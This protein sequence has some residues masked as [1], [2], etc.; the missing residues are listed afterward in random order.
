MG[1]NYVMA[2]F[3]FDYLTIRAALSFLI[4]FVTRMFETKAKT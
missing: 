4:C 1:F 2:Q 3:T